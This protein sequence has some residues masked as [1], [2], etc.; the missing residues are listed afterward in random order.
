[1]KEIEDIKK[2]YSDIA[3]N[4]DNLAGYE[5]PNTEK[6]RKEMKSRHQKYLKGHDI[7]EIACGT[8]YW[9]EVIAKTAHSI[10]SVDIDKKMISRAKKRVAKF[11][12]VTFKIADAYSLDSIKGTFSAAYAHWWWSHIPKSR[13]RSFLS[14][15]HKKLISNA[16]VLFSNHLPNYRDHKLKISHNKFGDRLEERILSNGKK[17]FVVKNF[18]AK[19]E[20]FDYVSGLAK[21]IHFFRYKGFWELR[22]NVLK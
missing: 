10:L 7:L 12:N 6:I 15:L 5:D 18:L 22:Y 8:G 14:N 3:V 16:F 2:Y 9:T 13:I 11:K 19:R 17:Y 1:M 4:Y 20:A 21:N